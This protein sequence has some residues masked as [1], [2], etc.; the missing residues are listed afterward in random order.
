M[1]NTIE[2]KVNEIDFRKDLY[3]R[4]D[5][6]QP[7]ITATIQRYAQN[8]D[9]LPPI[10]INQHNILID[11]YHRWAAHR[12][13]DAEIIKV[14]VTKTESENELLSLAIKRN[15]QDMKETE[16][17]EFLNELRTCTVINT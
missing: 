5:A 3:P 9:A 4:I 2:L 12:S 14:F 11:G 16:Y 13:V 6:D 15:G 8:I 1:K 10:E 17:A 7:Q